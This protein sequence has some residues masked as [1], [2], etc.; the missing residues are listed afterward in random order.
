MDYLLAHNMTEMQSKTGAFFSPNISFIHYSIARKTPSCKLLY[1]IFLGISL[2]RKK[3]QTS[4]KHSAL[5]PNVIHLYS[6][7]IDCETA[8]SK[9]NLT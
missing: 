8:S 1:S 5:E 6:L 4:T 2:K 9:G 3:L 7:Q